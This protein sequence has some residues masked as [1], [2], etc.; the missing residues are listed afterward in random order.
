MIPESIDHSKPRRIICL[1]GPT[2]AGKTAASLGLANAFAG[3]VVNCDSRQV[4]AD[5]PIITAQPSPEEQASCPH[6]L[7]GFLDCQEKITAGRFADMAGNAADDVLAAGGTPILVGGAGLYVRA[8]LAGLAPIPPVPEDVSTKLDIDLAGKGLPELRKELEQADPEWAAR[9]HPNDTQRTLRG[10]EVFRGTGRPLSWWH[11]QPGLPPRFAGLKLGVHV[12]MD[13][14]EPR[15]AA[16]I[17]QM[18]AQGALEEA[19]RAWARCPDPQAP[20]WSGIG[21]AEL[22]AHLRGQLSLDEAK[23]RWLRN[24]RAYAK[25]QFTWFRKEKDVQWVAPQQVEAMIAAARSFLE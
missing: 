18:L 11:R 17:D 12:T 20:G 24:T 21:C 19:R 8:L 7:F 6:H 2:G 4:Y 1:L 9:V 13:E 3:Q 22:L 25:R 15:L 14:L 10:L 16:R 23:D 5:F